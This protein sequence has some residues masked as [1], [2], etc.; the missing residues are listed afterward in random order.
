MEQELIKFKDW[1]ISHRKTV[2]VGVFLI[3]ALSIVLFFYKTP[4]NFPIG[5][6]IAVDNGNSLQEIT[7]T[8]YSKKIIRSPFLFRTHVILLGGEKGVLAGDY[9]LDK[10]EGPARLAYRLVKGKY[11]LESK[12]I[13][14]PEGWNIFQIGDYLEKTLLRFNKKE[15]M[16]L[17]K[18]SEGYL[19]PDTYFISPVSTP[20][21]VI[22]RMKKNFN[23]KMSLINLSTSTRSLKDIIIMASILEVEAR[24]TESRKTIAGILWKRLS[25][26]M[27]LQ[28]DSTFLYINGKNTY[29]LTLEDLKIDSLYNT[30]KYPGLPRGPIGNPGLDSILAAINPI[31]T[32]YLYFLSSKSGGMYYGTTFEQHKRNKELY[33]NK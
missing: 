2:C 13:T 11:H 16:T 1:V 10:R 3:S 25:I 8:L 23:E 12:K 19:F 6:V 29:E 30:Y 28:V 15:F 17:A 18:D 9:I 31:N 24:T 21:G 14:I 33:L 26:G 7:D 22:D 32:K 20:Q 27:A 4:R 5:E